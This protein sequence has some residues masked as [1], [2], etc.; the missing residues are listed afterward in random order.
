M[1]RR[2]PIDRNGDIHP[3]AFQHD[4]EAICADPSYRHLLSRIPDH[5]SCWPELEDWIDH[6][7]QDPHTCGP[8]PSA[9]TAPP[10]TTGCIRNLNFALPKVS[11]P[12]PSRRMLATATATLLLALSAICITPRWQAVGRDMAQQEP[13]TA[14]QNAAGSRFDEERTIADRAR[15]SPVFDD[16]LQQMTDDLDQAIKQ[17]NEKDAQRLAEQIDDARL[18]K[19]NIQIGE[20][21][22]SL[23]T[24]I[25]RSSRLG[26]APD[27]DAK[28]RMVEL[29]NT[30]GSATVDESNLSKARSASQ[31]LAD[32]VSS[33]EKQKAERDR[34]AQ[35]ERERRAQEQHKQDQQAMRQP[36]TSTVPAPQPVPSPAPPSVAPHRHNPPSPRT[37]AGGTDGV[38]LE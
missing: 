14:Q 32:A 12:H 34:A 9:P 8:P 17:R 30:W 22:S 7:A 4:L 36:S 20:T 1:R 18:Q 33:C 26:D 5:A 31:D 16:Q 27:G 11:L 29:V 6:Y 38:V 28:K 35:L 23:S 10:R 15:K 13:A 3:K 24:S 2:S 37:P 19:L 25:E 21:T